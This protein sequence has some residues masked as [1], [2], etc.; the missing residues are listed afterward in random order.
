MIKFTL[1]SSSIS[2]PIKLKSLMRLLNTVL[3]AR[4][5]R[6]YCHSVRVGI[7]SAIL[8]DT[9]GMSRR[10]V[11]YVQMAGLLHDV[12][13]SAVNDAILDKPARLSADEYR[14]VKAHPDIGAR[15]LDFINLPDEIVKAVAQH[16]ETFDGTGYPL[17]LRG[18]QISLQGRILYLAEVFDTVTSDAPYRDA[19]TIDT[20]I[21]TIM[22]MSGRGLDPILVNALL[23]S[24]EITGFY[25]RKDIVH[26]DDAVLSLDFHKSLTLK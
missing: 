26:F 19:S 24:E 7:Y 3:S 16:H 2:D 9:I 20:A 6:R 5:R 17:G 12:G 25:M 18:E 4:S 8:A 1:Y 22:D 14:I 11:R 13:L 23:D 10:Q 15:M 21:D